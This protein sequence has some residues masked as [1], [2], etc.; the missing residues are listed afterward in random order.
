MIAMRLITFTIV[1][2][3]PWDDGADWDNGETWQ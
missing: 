3:V 2:A 1:T